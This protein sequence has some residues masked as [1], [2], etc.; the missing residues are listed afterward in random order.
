MTDVFEFIQNCF[1]LIGSPFIIYAGWEMNNLNVIF[2]AFFMTMG[3]LSG[4]TSS[5]LIMRNHKNYDEITE[6]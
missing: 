5:C 1:Y 3:S 6:P 4:V 2:G